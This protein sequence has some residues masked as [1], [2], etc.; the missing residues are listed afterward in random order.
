MT[1]INRNP[2]GLGREAVAVKLLVHGPLTGT[3][4]AD[5]TGWPRRTSSQVLGRLID[6]QR[7][8]YKHRR[9]RREYDLATPEP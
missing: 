6:A 4:F 5:I 3:Q 7:V 9:G 2:L 8:A 1:A